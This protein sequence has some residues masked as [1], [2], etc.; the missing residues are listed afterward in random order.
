LGEYFL[1]QGYDVSI[2]AVR[3]NTPLR[4]YAETLGLE[5]FCV[6]KL[7]VD[8]K[9]DIIWA[10]HF[11]LLPYLIWK[12]IKYVRIINSMM[13]NFALLESPLFFKE[14]IDIEEAHNFSGRSFC[15][16]KTGEQIY[17][18]IMTMTKDIIK[19]QCCKL[20]Q[21]AAE[22]YKLSKRIDEV[23]KMVESLPHKMPVEITKDNKLY[24]NYCKFIVDDAIETNLPEDVAGWKISEYN[25]DKKN[26]NLFSGFFKRYFFLKALS[27]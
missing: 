8:V 10:C 22:R 13:S 15:L 24:F 23:L 14:N 16:K 12:G 3:I 25:M 27:T 11:P 20:K 7:P 1:K 2:A 17:N 9:Y 19:R 26:K 4:R 21:I 5:V 6:N 18:E